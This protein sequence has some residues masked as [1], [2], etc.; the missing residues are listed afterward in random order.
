MN[1]RVLLIAAIAIASQGSAAEPGKSVAGAWFDGGGSEVSLSSKA[2]DYDRLTPG[3]RDIGEI[4]QL[5]QDVCVHAAIGVDAARPAVEARPAWGF[6]FL[7]VDGGV[8]SGAKLD[9]W[10]AEDV[11]VT[12]QLKLWP[13][14]ECNVLASRIAAIEPPTLIGSLSRV[15]GSQPDKLYRAKS[16]DDRG[17]D[18]MTARWSVTGPSGQPRKVYASAYTDINGAHALHLGLTESRPK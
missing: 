4:L 5:F 9:G 8:P 10:Q 16:A 3:S 1:H 12:S 14:A 7:A 11:S 17:L 15:L 6:R 13:L 2:F 18:G